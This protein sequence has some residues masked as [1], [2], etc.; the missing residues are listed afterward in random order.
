[1]NDEIKIAILDMN[2]NKP[3]Q[4]LKNI[5]ELCEEFKTAS[6]QKV[7]IKVFDVRYKSKIPNIKDYDIFI[8][9]GGPGNPHPEG[10]PWEKHYGD[11]LDKL[12]SHNQNRP[13]KKFAFLIC[14]SFQWAVIHWGLATV[15]KRKSY[16]FGVM[17]IHKT[18]VG[19]SEFLY[20]NLPDPFFAIDSRAFQCVQP[21]DKKLRSMG[22]KVQTLEKI[23]PHIDLERAIMSIRF[24]KEIIGTQFHPEASPDG[25]MS[26]LKNKEYRNA[27]IEDYGIEKFLET[28]DRID[29]DDKIVLTRAQIL[30]RFLKQ[31]ARSI[32]KQ[33]HT[34]LDKKE[35]SNSIKKK[36]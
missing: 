6:R 3:N 24:S 17:P 15:N 9:S 31:S 26:S 5:V 20:K 13:N 7:L 27:M 28:L 8:S 25:L 1:M 36:I 2:D 19:K 33:R 23:R 21:N 18:I 35:K 34:N 22:A 16:S 14:H 32:I 29:D 10:K 12:W 11:F 30:P 4:G